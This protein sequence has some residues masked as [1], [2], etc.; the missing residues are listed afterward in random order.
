MDKQYIEKGGTMLRQEEIE[1]R[2]LQ[3]QAEQEIKSGRSKYYKVCSHCGS[4]NTDDCI[5]CPVC[6]EK[7]SLKDRVVRTNFFYLHQYI[8]MQARE[9]ERQRQMIARIISITAI[10]VSALVTAINIFV[11]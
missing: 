2:G 7:H 8:E 4:L 6:G 1:R 10:G 5:F 11:L 9:K 3:A